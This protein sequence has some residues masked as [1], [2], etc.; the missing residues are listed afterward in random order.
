MAAPHVMHQNMKNPFPGMNP[1]L[2]SFWR[3]VHA[4]LLVYACDQLN[5]ELPAGMKARVDELLAI[6]AGEEKPRGSL[7]DVAV[8]E[9]WDFSEQILRHL[10]IV[11]SHSHII[12]A[13]ELLSPSNKEE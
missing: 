3:D 2:E 11:D 10:E 8:T 5:A 12:T 1:W 13:I 7:P 4:K 6:D 9:A